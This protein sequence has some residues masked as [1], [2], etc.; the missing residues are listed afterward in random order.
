M[1]N[2]GLSV[3]ILAFFVF[4]SGLLGA[5][6]QPTIYHDP[7]RSI[8]TGESVGI[9]ASIETQG[10]PVNQV[11]MHVTTSSDAVP[12]RIVMTPRGA[13]AYFGTIP[14]ALTRNT[15]IL[16]YYIE[17]RTATDFSETPFHSVQVGNFVEE[18]APAPVSAPIQTPAPVIRPTETYPP[19]RTYPSESYPP[20]QTYPTY[21]TPPA[22]TRTYPVQ[23]APPPVQTAPPPQSTQ[24]YIPPQ[25]EPEPKQQKNWKVPAL[26]AAGAVAIG[27][28]IWGTSSGDDGGDSSSNDTPP[29]SQSPS[30][31]TQ[32]T[33]TPTTTTPTTTTPT[34]TTPTTTIPSENEPVGSREVITQAANDSVNSAI[35]D[36]PVR[37]TIDATPRFLGRDLVSTSISLS[38][39]PED[40]RAE[41]FQ[42]LF[43]NNV[44]LDTGDVTSSGNV[45]V[46]VPQGTGIVTISIPSSTRDN[47]LTHNWSW[48]AS[49][50][51]VVE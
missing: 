44:V 7:V 13:G 6:A 21:P 18:A 37:T 48:A 11:A 43:D 10:Q 32:P 2:Q 3:H 47:T 22:P 51:Y 26:I 33:T 41:R 46:V 15:Q 49:I 39:N 38:Y 29:A 24:P 14:A 4:V 31:T 8:P 1:I 20:A 36:F 9:I 42:V 50:A 19:A 12:H 30:Q 5:F 45:N 23:P 16:R 17:A 25:P 28:A 34:T 35:V 40:N 27:V